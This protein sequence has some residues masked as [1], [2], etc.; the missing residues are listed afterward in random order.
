MRHSQQRGLITAMIV[1][2]VTACGGA[3]GVLAQSGCGNFNCTGITDLSDFSAAFN[4]LTGSGYPL[5][6]PDDADLDGHYLY[7]WYDLCLLYDIGVHN[8]YGTCPP[9][10]PPLDPP[11]SAGDCVLYDTKVFPANQGSVALSLFVTVSDPS[12]W[13]FYPLKLLVNDQ[14]PTIDSVIKTGPFSSSGLS[15]NFRRYLG[16]SIPSDTFPSARQPLCKVYLSMPPETTDRP[17]TVSFEPTGPVQDA[18]HVGIPMI[19]RTWPGREVVTPTIQFCCQ[20]ERGNVNT[21][22]VVDLTDLSILVSFLTGGGAQLPCE[23]EANV[24]GE[25]IVDLADLSALVSYL[26]GGGYVLPACG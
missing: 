13:F 22:G 3:P 18:Q 5:S 2:A 12:D 24:N 25:G 17:I 7:T 23:E 11:V 4:Y 26:T 8:Q 15:L 19:I 9:T 16:G 20:G 10:L 21:L 1:I 6:C 14:A